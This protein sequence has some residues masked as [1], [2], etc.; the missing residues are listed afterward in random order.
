MIEWAG[1]T[2]KG[3]SGH[4]A[5]LPRTA[6]GGRHTVSGDRGAVYPALCD[7]QLP[8]VRRNRRHAGGCGVFFYPVLLLAIRLISFYK[9]IQNPM[10]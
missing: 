8:Q 3:V 4:A 7:P 2:G 1:K 10:N 6:S 5:L 9:L